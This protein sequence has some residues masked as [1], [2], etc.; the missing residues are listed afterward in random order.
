MAL[1]RP[2]LMK[3][4]FRLCESLS[5]SPEQLGAGA[6]DYIALQ[7]GQEHLAAG[8]SD[9]AA[10][11]TCVDKTLVLGLRSAYLGAEV[12]NELIADYV[13]R[14]PTAIGVAAV[15]PTRHD[16]VSLAEELLDRKEFRGLTISPALQNFHPADSRAMALYELADRRGVPI[17]ICQGTLFPFRLRNEFEEFAGLAFEFEAQRFQGREADGLR[18]VGLEDREVGQCDADTVRQFRQTDAPLEHH[19]VQVELDGHFRP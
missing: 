19:A 4:S 8:P 11:A 16:A 13:G 18:L 10:A 9:H 6:K 12:P 17:F 15:D 5:A 2:L 3:A 1:N 7:C 14:N